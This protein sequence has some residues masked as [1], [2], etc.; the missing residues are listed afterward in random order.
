[1]GSSRV[2]DVCKHVGKIDSSCQ[3]HQHFLNAF[4]AN[5][6]APKI[7][8]LGEALSNEILAQKM[9]FCTKNMRVKR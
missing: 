6:L 9:S 1:V 2:K 5:I 7:T 3:F 4:F 8:K